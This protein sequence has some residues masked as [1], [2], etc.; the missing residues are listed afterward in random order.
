MAV[1]EAPKV[2]ASSSKPAQSSTPRPASNTASNRA[3]SQPKEVSKPPEVAKTDR[4]SVSREAR[5]GDSN[6]AGAA[7]MTGLLGGLAENYGSQ[8]AAS[9]NAARLGATPGANPLQ[10]SSEDLK[11]LQAA[12]DSGRLK[13]SPERLTQ[14]LHDDLHTAPNVPNKGELAQ[15]YLKN[16]REGGPIGLK[17]DFGQFSDD[18][19][20]IYSAR[21]LGNEEIVV[22][23]SS[24]SG[25]SS[26]GGDFRFTGATPESGGL[27]ASDI[28][29]A[30]RVSP[31][32]FKAL[33]AE[34]VAELRAQGKIPEGIKGIDDFL[35]HE[36]KLSRGVNNFRNNYNN[37]I[38]RAY[39]IPGGDPPV[40]TLQEGLKPA[41]GRTVQMSVVQQG[42][43]FDDASR[44]PL[45]SA[46]AAASEATAASKLGTVARVGG[47]A[48]GLAGGG[49][50]AANGVNELRNGNVV[51]GTAD[52]GAGT[53]NMVAGGALLAGAG[54]LAAGAGGVG[55]II[56]G[57]RDVIQGVRSGNTE[58]A[59]V[60]GVKSTAG[61]VMMAGAMTGNP[62]LVAGGAIAYGGAVV[63]QNREAI[64]NAVSAG[65]EKVGQWASDA[66]SAI[67]NGVSSLG[68]AASGLWNRMSFW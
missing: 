67:S 40:S 49:L 52:V 51:D 58:Q 53:A 63:Y 28:D 8:A 3:T 5:E 10:A 36:G 26:K 55:A 54:T 23:G 2:S 59:V 38:I 18:V 22:H 39:N 6:A 48:L 56:D 41:A 19:R 60:G 34:R 33:G 46:N 61:A 1:K 4:T 42:G 45:K 11:A 20:G 65:A 30:A 13:V 29:V 24:A 17:Q 12:Q 25:A 37:G 64:G 21:G 50:Q 9:E 7:N 16:M 57:G 68:N 27:P 15:S 35:A 32:K 66:G 43:A 62:F 47:G 31:E 14:T 44:I